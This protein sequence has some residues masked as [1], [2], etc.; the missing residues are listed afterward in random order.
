[1]AGKTGTALIANGKNGYTDHIYQ[2]SFAGYFP[3]G[4][5]QYSCI[6]VIRNKPFAKKF[7]GAAVAGPVFKEVADKLYA[8]NADKDGSHSLYTWSKDSANYFYA[9][10]AVDL[11]KVM[12]VLNLNFRDS[13][14]KNEWSRLYSVNNQPV[15]NGESIRRNIMPDVRGMGLK[16]VLYLLEN[17]DVKVSFRGRGKVIAQSIEPGTRIPDNQMIT[18]DLN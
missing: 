9:G 14:I 17:L 18:V 10:S 1:V 7:Y 4:D 11:K 8:L 6:V 16:D 13:A 5:P 3:A 2:S 15:I 12:N